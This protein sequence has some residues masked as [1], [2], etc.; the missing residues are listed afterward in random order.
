MDFKCCYGFFFAAGEDD[1]AK[2]VK[3]KEDEAN[4]ELE[5]YLTGNR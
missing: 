3:D 4:E 2:E 1:D 5:G